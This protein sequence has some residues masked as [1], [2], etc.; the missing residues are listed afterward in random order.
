MW[1]VPRGVGTQERPIAHARIVSDNPFAF[2]PSLEVRCAGVAKTMDG[3][4][5]P[6]GN[7]SCIALTSYIHVGRLSANYSSS[8]EGASFVQ[9][10]RAR[11]VANQLQ[12]FHS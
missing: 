7:C 9:L 12:T 4:R 5:R 1:E 11:R 10:G 8:Y 3:R 6:P 2:P